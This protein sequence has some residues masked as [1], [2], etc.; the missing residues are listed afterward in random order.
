[1][2]RGRQH[3][4]MVPWLAFGH[5]IPFLQLSISLAKAGFLS[6]PRNIQRLPKLPQDLKVPDHLR[7]AATPPRERPPRR[8]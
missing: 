3:V 5:L 1:M 2:K 7:R 4:A 6:T 8:R